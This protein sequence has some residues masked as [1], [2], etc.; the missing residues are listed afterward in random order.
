MKNIFLNT[1]CI[2]ELWCVPNFFLYFKFCCRK[3]RSA[4]KKSWLDDHEHDSCL[5][6]IQVKMTATLKL[7][8]CYAH[9][10]W[11]CTCFKDI[12]NWKLFA[13]WIFSL[14]YYVFMIWV[15]HILLI[16]THVF[17]SK[18]LII[19][20]CNTL[21]MWLHGGNCLPW[22]QY[23]IFVFP[24]NLL[25]QCMQFPDCMTPT[26]L[27]HLTFCVLK[28]TEYLITEYVYYMHKTRSSDINLHKKLYNINNLSLTR[29]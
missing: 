8:H 16:L 11:T 12:K 7:K 14:L 2:S 26:H 17:N 21:H 23:E 5:S 25:L 24:F 28:T 15:W 20:E 22:I 4:P 1:P 6:K 13:S 18:F 3:L 9:P 19:Q 10:C 29:F 27:D